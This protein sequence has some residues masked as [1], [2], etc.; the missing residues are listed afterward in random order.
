[1][2]IFLLEDRG[3]SGPQNKK[4]DKKKK[5]KKDLFPNQLYQIIT[6]QNPN[7]KELDTYY[8]KTESGRYMEYKDIQDKI[9]Q[10]SRHYDIDRRKETFNIIR[11]TDT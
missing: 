11:I 1:M 10:S 7:C 2:Y 8:E 3:A 9:R 6:S 4:Q 5:K